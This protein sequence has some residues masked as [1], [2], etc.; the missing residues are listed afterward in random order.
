MQG[1]YAPAAQRQ[2]ILHQHHCHSDGLRGEQP[3]DRRGDGGGKEI[4][5]ERGGWDT[6]DGLSLE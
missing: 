2:H 1:L 4:E 6:C 3:R 5:S